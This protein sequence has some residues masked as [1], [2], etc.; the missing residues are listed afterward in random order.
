M[1]ANVTLDRPI[2]DAIGAI[3]EFEAMRAT[4][5]RFVHPD[6]GSFLRLPLRFVPYISHL[7]PAPQN[8]T[9]SFEPQNGQIFKRYVVR[10]VS[11]Q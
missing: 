2:W 3:I 5:M 8:A 1:V 11:N 9:D 4:N 6:P 7:I 10:K